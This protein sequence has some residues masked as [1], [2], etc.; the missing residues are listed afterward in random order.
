MRKAILLFLAAASVAA[1]ALAQEDIIP[2]KRSRLAKMGL[3]GGLTPSY[4]MPDLGGI[5]NFLVGAKAAPLSTNGVFL[6]G[7]AGAAYIVVVPNLRVGGMGM[8]GGLTSSA[9]DA[10]GI[11]RDAELRIGWGGVTVE[12]VIPVVERLDV[13]VGTLIGHGGLDLTL[14]KSNGGTETWSGQLSQF[15]DALTAATSTSSRA[16][17]GSFWILAPSVNV[18]YAV[19]GWMAIRL[20]ASYTAMVGPNW[21]VDGTYDLLN[22]PDTITGK[23][24][25]INAGIL[26]GIF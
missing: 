18:E 6:W 26:V 2:P 24:F 8:G 19:L 11:R 5:N 20:G 22:V 15:G 3:F 25:M 17:N 14:R 21:K 13:A 23:G 16:L 10:S 9:L 12:Y 7:G 4:L 1:S